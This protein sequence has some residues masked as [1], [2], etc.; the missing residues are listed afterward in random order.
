MKKPKE[1]NLHI[2]QLTKEG[3]GLGDMTDKGVV[4]S[5]EVPFTLP[6]DEVEA[7][8]FKRGRAKLQ[9]ICKPSPL[10]TAPRCTHFG[11]C[12]GCRLQHMPYHE[13]LLFKERHISDLFAPL[14]TVIHPIIGCE[15]PW[16]YRNKMEFSFSSDR[17]GREF[18]G[19]MMYGAGQRV[20]QLEQCHLAPTWFMQGVNATR[21][22]WQEGKLLAY[23]PYKNEGSLRTL[24]LREGKHSKDRLAMLTVSGNPDFALSKREIEGWKESMKAAIGE[25]SSLFLRIQQTS[26]GSAT[27]FYEIHLNGLDHL[28]EK[29]ADLECKVSP[30]A[31]FQPFTIQAEKLCMRALEMVGVEAEA[32]VLD[33]F[34]GT[35][36]LGLT[37]ARRARKVIGIDLSH[38]SIV[39]ARTNSL[40][41]GLGSV[42][43]YSG[44][45]SNVLKEISIQADLV[46]VDPP[47]CGL[48]ERA[49][50]H[51]KNISAPSILY[52]SCNPSTQIKDIYALSEYY[53]E[54]IQPIDQFPHTIH[55][56]NI[57]ILRKRGK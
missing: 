11:V 34:C 20:V 29:I 32:T 14:K 19:L 17:A 31:F 47:R 42:E 24:I 4:E 8:L 36:V 48:G 25:E 16:H 33:L 2:T 22:W 39:D 40:V 26:K 52:I 12:G 56:E 27:N 57:A 13:Q 6:G 30:S 51:L 28:R 50:G 10:R 46:I 43:F 18:L 35:G 38:E 37:A 54:A 41:N 49:I 45:V 15:E 21:K 7:L 5:V 55:I 3:F 53:V 23:H 9:A 1:V 44:D